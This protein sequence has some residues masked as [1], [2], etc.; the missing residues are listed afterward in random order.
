M[1]KVDAGRVP[2]V[3]DTKIATIDRKRKAIDVVNNSLVYS[4]NFC[5]MDIYDAQKFVKKNVG[6]RF[7]ASMLSS[8]TLATGTC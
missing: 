6:D 8:N 5:E 1:N 4:A 7:K 2:V 3:R